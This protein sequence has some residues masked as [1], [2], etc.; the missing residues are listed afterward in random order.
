M[1]AQGKLDLIKRNTEEI[2]TEEELKK[3]LS[4][5]KKLIAYCG[6]EPNGPIH[7]GHMVTINKL[8]DLEKA[9]FKIIILLADVHALLNR[10]GEEATIKKEVEVWKKTIKT[11]G[12]KAE[13]ILGSK[14]Q[15]KKEYQYDVMALAQHT[16]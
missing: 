12:I 3:L 5:K 6:Y 14:F 11:M 16:T 4:S 2:V 7:L 13:I 9:G 8:K 1:N 15:Y 10:K